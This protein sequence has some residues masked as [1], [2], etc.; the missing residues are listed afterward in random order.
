MRTTIDIPDHLMKKAKLKAVDEGI[1]LKEL[2]TEM[3]EKELSD[4]PPAQ[5]APWKELKGMGSAGNLFPEDSG[6]DGYSGP[7]WYTGI[8]VNEPDGK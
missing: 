8:G 3:L 4:G 2:F 1:T 6:F 5:K 7:D